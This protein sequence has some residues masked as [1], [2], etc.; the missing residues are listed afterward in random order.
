MDD[1][2][3]VDIKVYQVDKGC[4]GDDHMCRELDHHQPRPRPRSHTNSSNFH[5]LHPEASDE[6]HVTVDSSR[7]GSYMS[8]SWRMIVFLLQIKQDRLGLS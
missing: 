7:C 2:D 5:I 4:R 3:Q 8:I 1:E 6:N